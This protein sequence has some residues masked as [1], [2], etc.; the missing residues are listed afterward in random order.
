MKK[1]II[2]FLRRG[3]ISCGIG[4][5]VLVIFYLVL[6]HTCNIEFLTVEEVSIGIFSISVLAFVAGGMNSIYQIESLPLMLSIL[7][8]GVV[9]YIS[10]LITYLINDWIDFSIIPI[11]VFSV[12][13]VVGYIVIWISIYLIIKRNTAKINAKLNKNRQEL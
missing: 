6:K 12:I 7:I 5:I 2:G 10:Y 3:L 9:L 1:F 11:I 13:F 8:H 4:P